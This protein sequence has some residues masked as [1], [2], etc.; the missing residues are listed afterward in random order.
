MGKRKAYIKK[1]GEIKDVANLD[2]ESMTDDMNEPMNNNAPVNKNAPVNNAPVNNAPVNKNAPVNNAPVNNAPVDNTPKKYTDPTGKE[3]CECP[4]PKTAFTRLEAVKN[5]GSNANQAVEEFQKNAINN[6]KNTFS[7]KK[8]ELKEKLAANAHKI[9]GNLFGNTG[10]DQGAK[11]V[12]IGGRRRRTR[13]HK[14]HCNHNL[15]HSKH[16]KHRTHKRCKRKTHCKH[17]KT[18]YKH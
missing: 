16:K 18:K 9:V 6:V 11:E 13:K 14:K 4:P 1:G 2:E 17:R 3:W 7:T 12:T 8:D 10:A 5:F 15:C